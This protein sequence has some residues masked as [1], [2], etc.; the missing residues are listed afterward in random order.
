MFSDISLK[1]ALLSVFL[2]AGAV[3]SPIEKRAACSQYTIISTRGTGELQGPSAGF[4]TM[5]QQTLAQVSGGTVYNTVY[6]ADASQNSALGTQDIVNKVQSSLRTNPNMCFILQGYSQ[7]AA[8]TVNAMPKLTGANMDAVKGVFLIGDPE[9]R[10]G[11]ACNV[12]ANGG[13]TTKNVNGLSAVLGGIPA[14]WVPK[15]M[16]VCAYGDGV[17]DTTHGFGIN[18]QHLSYPYSS[19]VQ[20]MGTKY[21]VAKLNGS[22]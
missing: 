8:A 7:G 20:S 16:D 9:H 11:L 21:M 5:N 15:T 2:A 22:S 1:G 6:L 4:R 3:A 10:S 17:C 19:T 13:T 12:D 18:A 14:A